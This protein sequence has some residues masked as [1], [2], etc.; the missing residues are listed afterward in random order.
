[1]YGID[2]G[3]EVEGNI[4]LYKEDVHKKLVYE[5]GAL[6]WL[7]R[8]TGVNA[9]DTPVWFDD[10]G[11]QKEAQT[12]IHKKDEATRKEKEKKA[13]IIKASG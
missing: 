5:P 13:A 9:Y 12:T 8:K 1:M 10:Q 7:T 2:R 11:V 3:D 4:S 6:T